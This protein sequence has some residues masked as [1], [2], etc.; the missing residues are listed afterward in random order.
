MIVNYLIDWFVSGHFY[1]PIRGR[2]ELDIEMPYTPSS[3]VR[4]VSGQLA[5]EL[6]KIYGHWSQELYKK[7]CL[8]VLYSAISILN[9]MGKYF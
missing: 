5:L 9:F 3:V 8:E 4:S 1:K 7:V 2:G 6:E